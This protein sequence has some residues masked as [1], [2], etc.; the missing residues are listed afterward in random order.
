MRVR[1]SVC[2]RVCMKEGERNL[3]IDI[4]GTLN[5]FSVS[6]LQNDI[7][8]HSYEKRVCVCVCVCKMTMKGKVSVRARVRER[9]ST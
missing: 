2:V 1:G 5:G 8:A 7:S 4:D 3:L 6:L 9:E